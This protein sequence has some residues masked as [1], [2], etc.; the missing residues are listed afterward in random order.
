MFCK[1]SLCK[2][3]FKHS[4]GNLI[5]IKR[6][7]QDLTVNQNFEQLAYW[8]SINNVCT[9]LNCFHLASSASKSA[10]P[11][12][13][14]FKAHAALHTL[15]YYTNCTALIKT[16]YFVVKSF[17]LL[18]FGNQHFSL[19][20]LKEIPISAHFPWANGY[21]SIGVPNSHLILSLGKSCKRIRLLA[22][23][24]TIFSISTIPSV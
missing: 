19:S 20:F 11:H 17:Y 7:W 9:K 5:C 18:F 3:A 2:N 14:L 6:N 8:K 22:S 12:L 10:L 23:S 1:H 24:V 15:A 16:Q 21:F 4:L 13:H